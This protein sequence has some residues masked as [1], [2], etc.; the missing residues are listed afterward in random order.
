M[1]PAEQGVF[2]HKAFAKCVSW[3][4]S[5]QSL[6]FLIFTLTLNGA[7]TLNIFSDEYKE[8]LKTS[9]FAEVQV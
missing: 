9:C 5:N 1:Y 4:K 8:N 6:F 3:E 2:I 7:K